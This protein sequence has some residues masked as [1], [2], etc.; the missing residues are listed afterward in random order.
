MNQVNAGLENS[1]PVDRNPTAAISRIMP[2]EARWG[3]S[4]DSGQAAKVL[5]SVMQQKTSAMEELTEGHWNESVKWMQ[6]KL[7]YN[8]KT[9]KNGMFKSK[10]K[11]TTPIIKIFNLI[12]GSSLTEGDEKEVLRRGLKIFLEAKS[13]FEGGRQ[14]LSHFHSILLSGIFEDKIFVVFEDERYREV[15]PDVDWAFVWPNE[16]GDTE[17]Y[18]VGN[19]WEIRKTSGFDVE[20]GPHLHYAAVKAENSKRAATTNGNCTKTSVR[21]QA[22]PLT[23]PWKSGK[24]QQPQC[25]NALRLM[26]ASV[27]SM[28]RGINDN[29]PTVLVIGGKADVAADTSSLDDTDSKLAEKNCTQD[30]EARGCPASIA[31]GGAASENASPDK[32]DQ[33]AKGTMSKLRQSK[34]RGLLMAD[35]MSMLT[36]PTSKGAETGLGVGCSPG[37]LGDGEVLD[38]SRP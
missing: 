24:I 17:T 23:T 15:V 36:I 33:S 6:A 5:D 12:V 13:R 22:A 10:I 3:S 1:K 7:V 32:M 27:K 38:E 35:I 30:I 16:H 20:Q 11:P 31:L 9:F 4:S 14:L 34:V 8:S 25:Q 28:S 26:I 37:F 29:E 18:T 21:R 2:D 19:N